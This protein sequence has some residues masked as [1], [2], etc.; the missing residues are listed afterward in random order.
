M[1]FAKPVRKALQL[2]RTASWKALL[3]LLHLAST[4]AA[5]PLLPAAAA[6]PGPKVSSL[7]KRLL[8][9]H[10]TVNTPSRRR[11]VAIAT[12]LSPSSER[13]SPRL[14]TLGPAVREDFFVLKV[15]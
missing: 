6:P 15:I 3:S 2:P 9:W 14:P 4:A 1:S 12:A 8:A 13:R 5:W 11:R 10:L 7:P